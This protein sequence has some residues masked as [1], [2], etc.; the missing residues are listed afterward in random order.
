MSLLM[1][2]VAI[3]YRNFHMEK[4]A[5]ILVYQE[6]L[7]SV[8]AH[9]ALPR[10]GI[11]P[12]ALGEIHLGSNAGG[13]TKIPFAPDVFDLMEEALY[14]LSGSRKPST[15]AKKLTPIQE[16]VA[17][18]MDTIKTDYAAHKERDRIRAEADAASQRELL[19]QQQ[20]AIKKEQE[21]NASH[22]PKKQTGFL[23]R[24]L[25]G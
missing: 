23:S 12:D 19:R 25:W 16:E 17:R 6:S 21:Q 18:I 14:I 1:N 11:D 20:E 4:P 22:K 10:P 2:P 5:T 24:L 7:S 13:H 3:K 15:E 8:T 9:L